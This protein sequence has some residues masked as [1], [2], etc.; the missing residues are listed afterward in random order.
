MGQGC[1]LS[2]YLFNITLEILAGTKQTG[3]QKTTEDQLD[4]N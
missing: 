1:L 3:K 2:T 4:I